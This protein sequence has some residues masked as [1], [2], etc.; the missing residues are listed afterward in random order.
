VDEYA[1]LGRRLRAI[2][3]AKGILQ[4][5]IAA[6]LAMS[7]VGYGAYERGERKL[8]LMD[9][10]KIA[11]A[12]GIRRLTL[13]RLLGL[14][15]LDDTEPV[16]QWMMDLLKPIQQNPAPPF[17]RIL[18]RGR[19]PG[20]STPPESDGPARSPASAPHFATRHGRTRVLVSAAG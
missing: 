6:R 15:E 7:A 12:L 5:D 17:G 13:L 3:E 1:D 4:E 20:G 18:R 8:P 19:G 10:P 14:A 9:V 2:R 16:P 11:D